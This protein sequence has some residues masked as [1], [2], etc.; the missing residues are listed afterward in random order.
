MFSGVNP[1]QGRAKMRLSKSKKQKIKLIKR[2]HKQR[3]KYRK[4]PKPGR[5]F[6]MKR[7]LSR[8]RLKSSGSRMKNNG[9]SRKKNKNLFNTRKK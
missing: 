8:G 1:F 4:A 7:T 9:G 6:G 2:K 5:T 3:G